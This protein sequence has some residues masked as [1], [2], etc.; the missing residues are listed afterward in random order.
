[1]NIKHEI[2]MPNANPKANLTNRTIFHRLALGFVLDWL[3]FAL[4]YVGI[5]LGPRGF[6]DTNMLVLVTRNA[7]IGVFTNA[8]PQ[9]EWV[10]ILV[11]Y[12]LYSVALHERLVGTPMHA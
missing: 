9:Y 2:D 5:A 8:R 7:H 4:G 11:E 6:W 12:M 1:M 10:C 3:R